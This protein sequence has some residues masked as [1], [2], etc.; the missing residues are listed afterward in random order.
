MEWNGSD[1]LS[2]RGKEVLTDLVGGELEIA[3][4]RGDDALAVRGEMEVLLEA[5]GGG[6]DVGGGGGA[7]GESGGDAIAAGGEGVDLG[8]HAVQGGESGVGGPEEVEVDGE[9]AHLDGGSEVAAGLSGVIEVE[10]GERGER[11]QQIRRLRPSRLQHLLQL[12]RQTRRQ[13]RPH[14]RYALRYW[15][16]IRF[17]S[18][19]QAKALLES[20]KQHEIQIHR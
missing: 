8:L 3:E 1:V 12:P 2:R 18:I 15:N 5:V 14:F 17:N 16:P 13:G 11:G 19:S 9:R 10:G 7:G 20:N 4:E 6:D